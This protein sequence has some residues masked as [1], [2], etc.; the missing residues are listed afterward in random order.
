[1]FWALRES[2]KSHSVCFGAIA[3]SKAVK[4]FVLELSGNKKHVRR[5]F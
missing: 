2:R 1:L 5:L 3:I 4:T